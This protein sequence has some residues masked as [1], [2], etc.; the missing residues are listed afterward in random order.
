[1]CFVFIYFT[2]RHQQKEYILLGLGCV[3]IVIDMRVSRKISLSSHET[4]IIYT[5][6][7]YTSYW[8]VEYGYILLTK[9]QMYVLS[10]MYGRMYVF[11]LTIR[12]T[13]INPT[14]LEHLVIAR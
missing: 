5:S 1:M 7:V 9:I 11:I 6:V 13:S 8:L 3:L 4:S 12:H 10:S 2:T 14:T